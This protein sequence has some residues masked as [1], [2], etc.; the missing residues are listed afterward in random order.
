M[1]SGVIVLLEPVIDDDLGLLSVRKP[2]SIE[3][4]PAQRPIEPLVVSVLPG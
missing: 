2:F 3:N 4:L 1:R